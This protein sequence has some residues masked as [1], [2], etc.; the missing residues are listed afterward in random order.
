M[1]S[2][3][4]LNYI[5]VTEA[6][7]KWLILVHIWFIFR[8]DDTNSMGWFLPHS[9]QCS[10]VLW[11]SH[12]HLCELLENLPSPE[13]E[14]SISF[15]WNSKLS[16]R[17]RANSLRETSEES[18]EGS[19]NVNRSLCNFCHLVDSIHSDGHLVKQWDSW[20]TW[21]SLILG[22]PL[23]RRQHLWCRAWSRMFSISLR[24]STPASIPWSMVSTITLTT[25]PDLQIM[26]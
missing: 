11:T 23:T 4:Q 17:W 26:N 20:F 6:S 3:T 7:Y 22:T 5:L 2:T 14:G 24:F 9:F 12:C 15:L 19:E 18:N 13:T 8:L 25:A 1:R 16:K 10:S 21:I